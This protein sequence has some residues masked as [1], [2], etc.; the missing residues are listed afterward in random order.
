MKTIDLDTGEYVD[1][2]KTK[3]KGKEA[4]RLANLFDAM[5][6]KY[7]GKPIKT[8]RSYHIVINA[9]NSHRLLPAGIEKIF[10]D[11]FANEK[12]PTKDKVKLSWCLSANN[13]NQWKT[14]N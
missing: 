6:S 14:E 3:G 1:E 7:S 5:A 9:M 2:V 13:I 11:W 12:T 8:P 4:I 10:T